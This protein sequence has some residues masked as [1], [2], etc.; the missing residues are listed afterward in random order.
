MA[1]A[2]VA[3]ARVQLVTC[4]GLTVDTEAERLEDYTGV[5]CK[6]SVLERISPVEGVPFSD[7]H[8]PGV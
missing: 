8:I 6:D 3:S 7:L 1:E 2:G 5:A 4:W